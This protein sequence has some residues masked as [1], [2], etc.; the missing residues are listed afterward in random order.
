[1]KETYVIHVTKKCNMQCVYCYEQDKESEYTWEEIKNEVD[2]LLS[3]VKEAHIEYLGGEP[4]LAFDLIEKSYYYIKEKYT[5]VDDFTI[6]TN[7]TI[8][9]DRIIDFLKKNKDLHFSASLDG[10]KFSN[11]LR[12]IKLADNNV[13]NSYDLVISNLKRLQENNIDFT[14]HMVTHPY[15]V[16]YIFDSIINYYEMGMKNIDL[17][18]V[19]S[20]IKID[21]TYCNEFKKQVKKTIDY[22]FDNNISDLS[23]GIFNWLKPYDD[24][25]TYVYDKNGK[26]IFE[27]YGRVKEDY[28]SKLLK[29]KDYDVKRCNEK[30]EISEMIYDIRK[31]AYDY[32]QRRKNMGL[33]NNEKASQNISDCVGKVGYC[34]YVTDPKTDKLY[35]NTTLFEDPDTKDIT[36]KIDKILKMDEERDDDNIIAKALIEIIK[37]LD[38]IEKKIQ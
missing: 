16:S 29:N 11:Q 21:E 13:I 6:T 35:T 7:G 19:E 23:V 37:R 24:E 8:L 36:E 14:I 34:E 3:N 31:F 4:C 27:S 10:N 20:T 28:V 5:N 12:V 2:N 32:Y 1:M 22:I 26:L 30:T 18:T 33:L 15:N 9:N 38:R 17:G 25:R